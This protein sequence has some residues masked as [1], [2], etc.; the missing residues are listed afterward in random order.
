MHTRC[1]IHQGSTHTSA[2]DKARRKRIKAV[3]SQKSKLSFLGDEEDA[4]DSQP[5][6]GEDG[7]THAPGV[8]DGLDGEERPAHTP[9]L[10]K[11]PTVPTEFLPDKDREAVCFGGALNIVY[12]VESMYVTCGYL[13]FFFLSFSNPFSQPQPVKMM[14]I[15]CS[16]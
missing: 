5:A 8:Q 16:I 15:I 12:I 11:D 14:T 7:S 6:A 1:V 10:G 4:V 9:R 2:Q 3:L 13:L